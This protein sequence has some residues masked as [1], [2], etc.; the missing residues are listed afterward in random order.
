[1]IVSAEENIENDILNFLNLI[2]SKSEFVYLQ[3]SQGEEGIVGPTLNWNFYSHCITRIYGESRAILTGGEGAATKTLIV[4]DLDQDW[5]HDYPNP[6]DFK[7]ERGKKD[8]RG[9]E[10]QCFQ[11]FTI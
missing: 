5:D 11:P 3:S 6:P 9:K 1:M 2:L 8:M 7:M 10:R 4:N